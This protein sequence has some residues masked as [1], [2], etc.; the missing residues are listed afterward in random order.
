MTIVQ[1]RGKGLRTVLIL[2][3]A[4]SNFIL[5]WGSGQAQSLY[6]STFESTYLWEAKCITC[7][8][9][10]M[11]PT[12]ALCLVFPS[13]IYVWLPLSKIQFTMPCLS[14]QFGP[15]C[16]S[17]CSTIW[18]LV[19]ISFLMCP[20]LL[21]LGE[22]II[23][24][25]ACAKFHCRWRMAQAVWKSHRQILPAR[26][27]TLNELPHVILWC[28]AIQTQSLLCK[29]VLTR[30]VDVHSRPVDSIHIVHLAKCQEL[31]T[32]LC[33]GWQCICMPRFVWSVRAMTSESLTPWGPP[34]SEA[35]RKVKR[36]IR[37][38]TAV[39]NSSIAKAWT[40]VYV[41]SH[42]S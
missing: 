5:Y 9:G 30:L 1:E 19:N 18:Y 3:S 6:F 42:T 8:T 2:A 35:K 12:Q 29:I 14:C 38:A 10:A 33:R 20:H 34:I 31:C 28:V 21:L 4:E 41:V 17:L 32:S 13:S 36:D 7:C 26:Y 27:P 15:G 11:L 16:C 23:V 24:A 40:A 22:H 25:L 37:I 39:F